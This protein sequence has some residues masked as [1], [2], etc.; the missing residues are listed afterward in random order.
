MPTTTKTVSTQVNESKSIVRD[1]PIQLPR[2]HVEIMQLRLVGDSPLVCNKWSEKAKTQMLD[3]QMK[4]G[5]QGKEA[6]DP[7]A[8]YRA[9]LYDLGDGT[10]GFPAIAFK[11]AAVTACTSIDGITKVMARQAFHVVGELVVIDGTPSMRQDMVI[12]GINTSDIRFRGEFKQWATTVT[13]R[14]NSSVMSAEQV[15]HLF[16]TAGFA[17]GVG[18]NRP[19]K[20]GSW[21]MFHVELQLPA[22]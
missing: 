10:C 17:V 11:K 15:V 20:N 8:C 21:G 13:V 7:E 22:S 6:K 4:K 19:E 1:V 2:M 14:F 3:K 12:V 18:E 16:N 9:S 5:K